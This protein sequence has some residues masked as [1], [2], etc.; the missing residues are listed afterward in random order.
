MYFTRSRLRPNPTGLRYVCL[1]FQ[2]LPLNTAELVC[3][4]PFVPPG[5]TAESLLAQPFHIYDEEF[6]EIIGPNPT[7]TLLNQTDSDPIFHE[8]PIW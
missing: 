7:L 5:T 4:Q 8:A 6:L 3:R 2:P 1:N